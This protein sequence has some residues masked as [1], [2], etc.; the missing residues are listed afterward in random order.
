MNALFIACDSS[1]H[2]F[3]TPSFST[4]PNPKAMSV[5]F[6]VCLA[7]HDD[8]LGTLT[9][10]ALIT[11]PVT[12]APSLPAK[13]ATI[14][15]TSWIV[16]RR[17]WIGVCVF[18]ISTISFGIFSSISLCTGP[19]LTQ[20]TVVPFSPS[21]AAQHRV[22]PSRAALDEQ[23]R[24]RLLKPARAPTDPRLMMRALSRKYGSTA[25]VKS[26]MP[27]TLRLYTAS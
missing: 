2:D 27:R 15:A 1:M 17:F 3:L 7:L 19:G 4:W 13:P 6:S 9:P 5:S 18:C 21:S 12:H 25:C 10:L 8:I 11:C 23:Y 20:L 26:M 24:L 16:P 22:S 14:L